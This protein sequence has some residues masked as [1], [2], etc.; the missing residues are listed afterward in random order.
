MMKIPCSEPRN[1]ALFSYSVKQWHV[2]LSGC[3]YTER[4]ETSLKIDDY[5]KRG[6]PGEV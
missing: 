4:L 1:V 5:T 6:G 3:I 2:E